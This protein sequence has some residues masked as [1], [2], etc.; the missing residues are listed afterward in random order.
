MSKSIYL[1]ITSVQRK[2]LLN[3]R[4]VKYSENKNIPYEKFQYGYK[5]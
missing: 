4:N 5:A 3:M 2:F 1:I